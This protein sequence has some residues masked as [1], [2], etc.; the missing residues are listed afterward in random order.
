ML[1]LL[2]LTRRRLPLF[3]VL[4]VAAV[5]LVWSY[6]VIAQET[7]PEPYMERTLV[8]GQTKTIGDFTVE[9]IEAR[10]TEEGLKIVHL[11]P[12]GLTRNIIPSGWLTQDTVCRWKYQ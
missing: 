6:V 8:L 5:L 4:S 12:D 10:D 9:L 1:T 7:P 3:A 11:L 2:N